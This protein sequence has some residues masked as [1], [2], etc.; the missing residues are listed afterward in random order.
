MNLRLA[1]T[2]V[3]T[4]M[5]LVMVGLVVSPMLQAG[6]EETEDTWAPLRPLIGEWAGT[7]AGGRSQIEAQ[8]GFALG[9][10]FLEVSHRAMF[11]SDEKNPEG[12]IHEDTGF[13][14]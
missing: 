2:L 8:Y 7:G 4:L 9:G 1:S 11:S 10:E 12:E 3:L 13:I 6:E 5:V 14:S